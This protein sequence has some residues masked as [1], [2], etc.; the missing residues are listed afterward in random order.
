MTLTEQLYR[1]LKLVQK[2]LN[3]E[4]PEGVMSQR[5]ARAANA[6]YEKQFGQDVR[7]AVERAERG[8]L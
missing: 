5:C 1:A 8:S 3:T 6:W 2:T 7:Q 4:A